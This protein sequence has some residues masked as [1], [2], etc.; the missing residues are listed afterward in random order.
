MNAL[1]M[2]DSVA[3]LE[4][5]SLAEVELVIANAGMDPD[6]VQNKWAHDNPSIA[7]L[8]L[9]ASYNAHQVITSRPN[10][11]HLRSL[12]AHLGGAEAFMKDVSGDTLSVDGGKSGELKLELEIAERYAEWIAAHLE[13]WDGVYLDEP[14]R[15]VPSR[16]WIAIREASKSYEACTRVLKYWMPPE[17]MPHLLHQHHIAFQHHLINDLA[18]RLSGKLLIA[19]SA[20][21]A[22]H[23]FDGITLEHYH[24]P[25]GL[26]AFAKQQEWTKRRTGEDAINVMWEK[27]RVGKILRGRILGEADGDS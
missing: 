3:T 15:F 18:S 12:I 2:I 6:T 13:G 5:T 4:E 11:E 27:E 20:G 26:G 22:H 25:H 8:T 24:S 9:L 16:R 7:G 14:T 1:H 19:N 21:W 17:F 10:N 23:Q